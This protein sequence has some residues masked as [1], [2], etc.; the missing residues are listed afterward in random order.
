MDKRNRGRP[1]LEENARRRRKTTYLRPS[2][3]TRLQDEALRLGI[4]ESQLMEVILVEEL[5]KRA[6]KI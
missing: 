4:P 5:A 1:F 3:C 2:D 6:K